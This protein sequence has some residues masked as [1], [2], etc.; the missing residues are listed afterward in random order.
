MG[1]FRDPRFKNYRFQLT[2]QTIN[3]VVCKPHTTEP[4][5]TPTFSPFQMALSF[6]SRL[7]QLMDL[8]LHPHF[9]GITS[10]LVQ[11]EFLVHTVA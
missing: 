4:L 1:H 10:L 5:M 11:C 6:A 7:Q 9:S 8:D 2:G 3:T